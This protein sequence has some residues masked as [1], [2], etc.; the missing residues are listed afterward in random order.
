MGSSKENQ[1][2]EKETAN[3]M[4]GMKVELSMLSDT[5]LLGADIDSQNCEVSSTTSV[6][7]VVVVFLLRIALSTTSHQHHII[8]SV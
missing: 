3:I 5:N 8:R 2:R 1:A 4:V 7:V 6:V